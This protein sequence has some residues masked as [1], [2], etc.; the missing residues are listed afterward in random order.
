MAT[1]TTSRT[2]KAGA[3]DIRL[4]IALLTGVYGIVLTIMGAAVTDD[5]DIAK[6]GG[7]NINLWAGVGLLIFTAL[8]VVWALVRPIR[9]PEEP[10]AEDN[11]PR[12]NNRFDVLGE[13]GAVTVQACVFLPVPPGL[14]SLRRYCWRRCSPPRAAPT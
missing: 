1:P 10:A 12:P 5:A 14:V 9:V 2:R 11:T 3:F 4:I 7:V 13:A 8:F 6:A